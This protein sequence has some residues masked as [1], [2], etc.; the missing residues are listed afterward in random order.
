MSTTI[1][2]IDISNS[3]QQGFD[4]FFE[5][6]PRLLGFLVIL[7]VGYFIAK[8][9]RTIVTKA[10]EKAGLDKALHESE[11]GQYAEKISPGSKPSRLIGA[12]GFW[13]IFVFVLSAAIGALGIPAVTTFMNQVLAYLPNVIAAVVIFVLAG[14]VAGAVG[15][16]VH[17]TMGDTATG[18]MLR[19]AV[20]ALVMVIAVFMILNQLHIAQEIVTITYAALIGSVALGMA[21]AFGLGGRD[22]AGRM[23]EDAYDK[24]QDKKDEV[25][26]DLETGKERARD[27][28]EE[29]QGGG[30]SPTTQA[31]R[32]GF[33]PGGSTA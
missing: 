12:V 22:V 2:E 31:P 6:L 19:A 28:A 17:K 13:L 9:V 21:L 18:K 24:G 33:E 16:L 23:L 15:A 8:L 3:L 25:K 32:P 10:L 27:K 5:F 14:V 1:A 26:D 7:V 30:G 20:P 11:A 29:A 4:S